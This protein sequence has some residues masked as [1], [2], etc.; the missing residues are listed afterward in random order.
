MKHSRIEY[1]DDE[2]DIGNGIIVTLNYGW[3]F[4]PNEHEA[5][6]GFDFIKDADMAVKTSFPCD[7]SECRG[8]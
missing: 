2:R 1:W 3:S 6:R 4:E 7:C 5:V 8:S